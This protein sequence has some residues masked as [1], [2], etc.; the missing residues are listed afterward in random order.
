MHKKHKPKYRHK[1]QL[2]QFTQILPNLTTLASLCVGLSAV[3]FA[4]E[5]QR[6]LAV[7]SI[8]VSAI[9]DALDGRIARLLG[10]SSHFGAELDS[11][12]DSICFGVAPA[13]VI[14]LISLNNLPNIGWS[15][16]LFFVACQ[17]LR[18]ARFNTLNLG[19]CEKNQW[20]KK[21]FTGVPAPAGA[22]LALLPQMAGFAFAT[23][24]GHHVVIN[25]V[26][27]I[28]SGFLMISK[29]P[30]FSLKG[31]QVQSGQILPIMIVSAL[32]IAMLVTHT[33]LSLVCIGVCYLFSIPFSAKHYYKD[34]KTYST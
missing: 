22:M 28:L 34:R 29:I 19:I 7:L 24:W 3:R 31:W 10:A 6:S 8:I 15:V 11:L 13:I 33:W 2:L 18:L 9:L 30:T 12:A 21:Y 16:C 17:T 32:I 14:Y 1:I 26:A 23:D 4:L 25:G 27:L 20:E 5:E